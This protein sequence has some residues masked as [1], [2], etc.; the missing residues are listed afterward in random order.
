MGKIKKGK[1][2]S[3]VSLVFFIW[4][5]SLSS[6]CFIILLGPLP[7]PL[8]LHRDTPARLAIPSLPR[9]C[10]PCPGTQTPCSQCE[11]VTLSSQ[12]RNPAL[13]KPTAQACQ[14]ILSPLNLC[15][16]P[17]ESDTVEILC[18]CPCLLRLTTQ[19][20]H[21]SLPLCPLSKATSQ[22]FQPISP[23]NL[24]SLPWDSDTSQ[25]GVRVSLCYQ[26]NHL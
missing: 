24:C 23:L 25:L 2:N 11:C 26:A 15:S 19:P 6:S 20:G 7:R 13:P 17:R 5:V 21:V 8:L 9:T 3:F 22:I 4:F 18:A 14:P 12:T 16:L 1:N 10:T